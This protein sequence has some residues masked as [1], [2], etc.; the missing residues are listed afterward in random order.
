MNCGLYHYNVKGHYLEA[1]L[2]KPL[3]DFAVKVTGQDWVAKTAIVFILTSVFDRT[4][5][6]YQDRGYRFV[7]I[8][9]GHICQNLYLV[10]TA[11]KIKCCAIGGFIEDEI[12]RLLDI[13]M[14]NESVIY[15]AGVGK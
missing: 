10:S 11:L 1:L 14:T 15:V 2:K 3:I 8:E 13:Q 7:L 9:A 12:D 5:V 4:R 6:E